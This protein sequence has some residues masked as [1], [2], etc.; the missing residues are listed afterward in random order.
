MSQINV[1]LLENHPLNIIQFCCGYYHSL[2]LDSEGNVFVI[3]YNQHGNLGIG[4]NIDTYKF[5]QI[6]NI[7][8]IQSISC[9]GYTSHLID[10]DGNLWSF[11]NNVFGKLGLG[12][13]KNRIIPTKHAE[14]ISQVASGCCGNHFLFQNFDNQIFI[15]GKNQSGQLGIKNIFADVITYQDMNSDYFSIWGKPQTI[16]NR[17]K[18]AR[19]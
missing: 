15:T 10:F 19:K 4:T 6:E 16:H 2:F 18:S 5:N 9:V 3:G 17:V 1:C 14:G 8:P 7:P 11:G 13:L 12:D